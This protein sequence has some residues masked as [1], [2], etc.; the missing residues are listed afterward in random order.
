MMIINLCKD[1]TSGRRKD[2]QS[3]RR[4][5]DGRVVCDGLLGG[6]EEPISLS[7]AKVCI[8]EETK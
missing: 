5:G 6:S 1:H 4:V 8:R 7:S 2:V 3:V